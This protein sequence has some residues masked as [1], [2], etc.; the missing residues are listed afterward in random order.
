MLPL[1]NN[2]SQHPRP[3]EP[4]G[5]GVGAGVP[6]AE[7]HPRPA[8]WRVHPGHPSGGLLRARL[9]LPERQDDQTVPQHLRGAEKGLLPRL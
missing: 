7:R 5:C 9:A 8:E 1:Q 6:S 4:F 2:F 3:P